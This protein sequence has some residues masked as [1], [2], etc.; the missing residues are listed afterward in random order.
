MTESHPTARTQERH[1]GRARDAFRWERMIR[2]ASRCL[3]VAEAGVNHNG[4]VAIGHQLIEMAAD[5]GADAVKFQ[6]FDAAS[7]VSLRAA[8]APYQ[9][10]RSG[11]LGQYE[12]LRR[13]ALPTA[14]WKEY[15]DHARERGLLFLS[16]PFDR[17]S[18]Q[19]VLDAGVQ[20]LKIPSGELDNLA[21]IRSLGDCGL[22]LIISTGMSSLDEVSAAVEAASAAPNVA[23]LHCV[24]AYPAPVETS[25]LRAMVTMRDRFQLPVGWSDHTNGS[26]T[27]VIAV[28]LGASMLE[29][30]ITVDRHLPGPDHAASADPDEFA[31][32]VSAVRAT[33]EALGD[34]AKRPTSEEDAN[35][36]FVR[37]SYHASRDLA[38]GDT[39]EE[40]DVELL[41]P[42][43]GI[44]PTAVVVGRAVARA[45]AAGQPLTEGDLR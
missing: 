30:H 22:P 28:A 9:R 2:D 11:G 44:P 6:T 26:L 45:V 19:V 17:E 37:R 42:A 25:N 1:E 33:E 34:G 15:A 14:A 3:L 29:K 8:P 20:A 39:I 4:S 5:C 23:L 43:D 38:P 41:R 10:G 32:Y 13:L 12:M 40:A 35:R 21:F 27:A 31:L 36:R 24:S 7:L 18:L 16:S